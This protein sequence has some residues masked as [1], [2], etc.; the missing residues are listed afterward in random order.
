[1][2]KIDDLGWWMVHTT[3]RPLP[4]KSLNADMTFCA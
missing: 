4:A 2:A 3:L 1:M